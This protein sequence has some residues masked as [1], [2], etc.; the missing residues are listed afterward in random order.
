MSANTI[1]TTF[2]TKIL[3]EGI[4]GKAKTVQFVLGNG[5]RAELCLD[6]VSAEMMLQLAVHGLSQKGGDSTSG[7][8]KARDFAGAYAALTTV[9]DN[10]RNGVWASRA[11][12][13]TSD[14]VTAIARILGC[15]QE[16]AQSK[17]EKAS[18]E[19]LA[20]I[21]RHPQ[22]NKVVKELQA[23]RAKEAAKGA[24]KLEDVL[25]EIGL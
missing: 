22:I 16:E 12:G 24:G 17:V 11:G 3:P 13:G 6:E 8:S 14:L 5:L 10:L 21:K 23:A 7:F 18:E 25:K 9:L 1:T 19:Q 20:Q 15:S 4:G 2:L